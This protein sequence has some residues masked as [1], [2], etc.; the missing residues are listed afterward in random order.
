[1]SD[2]SVT[3]DVLL[4]IQGL[5]VHFETRRGIARAVNHVD[6]QPYRGERCGLGGAAG[7]GC[8]AQ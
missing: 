3:R 7:T 8:G 1:M 4:D 5:E 6:L 2:V